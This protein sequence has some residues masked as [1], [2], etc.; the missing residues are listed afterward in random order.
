[1][2]GGRVSGLRVSINLSGRSIGGSSIVLKIGRTPLL[3]RQQWKVGVV[4]LP[5]EPPF[6]FLDRPPQSHTILGKEVDRSEIHAKK[7]TQVLI[8][9]FSLCIQ[10]IRMISHIVKLDSIYLLVYLK[11]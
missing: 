5:Q 9:N 2:G 8:I 1:M 4:S 7:V 10:H 3:P 11:H 6:G